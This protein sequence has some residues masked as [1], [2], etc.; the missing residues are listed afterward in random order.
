[1]LHISLYVCPQTVVSS[2]SQA[3]DCFSLANHLAGKPLFR[4]SRCS[5]DGQAVQLPYA[6]IDVD[7]DLTL[8]ESADLLLLPAT[9]SD[10]ARTLTDNQTLLDWLAGRPASQSL[11]SLCS[12]AFLLAEAGQLDGG[13]AT[14]HWAL[15]S[16]FRQRYPQ[17]RLTRALYVVDRDVFTCS[18][19]TAALDMMSHFIGEQFGAP[20]AHTV[21][22]QF[23]H[24][25]IRG[26]EEAQRAEIPDRYAIGSPRLAKAIELMESALDVP[27]SLREIA[28]RV[29][30]ST[31]QIERLFVDELSVSPTAFYRQ[32]RLE[33]ARVLLRETLQSVRDVALESGFGSTAHLSRAY[34]RAFGCTPTE[35]RARRA[36]RFAAGAGAG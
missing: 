10:I 17:V 26:T 16:Q 24:P 13:T 25:R 33:R 5:R 23:I 22:E 30:V 15:A 27:L 18:G 9:G 7:G 29:G 31:R 1:M 36:G 21:A 2:L 6:R 19:G 12:S 34:K 8:A 20:L 32:R 35:E 4:L 28:L 3:H 14:T 11:A